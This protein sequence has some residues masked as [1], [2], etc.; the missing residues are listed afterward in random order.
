MKRL[1]SLAWSRSLYRTILFFT[2]LFALGLTVATQFE[3][4]TLGILTKKG[5]DFF[6]LFGTTPKAQKVSYDEIV[7]RFEQIDTGH[8]GSINRENIATFMESQPKD[9]L[10]DKL[11]DKLNKVLPIEKNALALALFITGVAILKAVTLFSYRFGTKLFAVY[12]G[13]DIRQRY[14]EHIQTLPMSFYQVHNIGALSSRAV[15]DAYVIADGINSALTNYIQTPFAMVSSIALCLAVSWKLSLV[16]FLGVP[17]VI[18]AIVFL[19]RRIRTISR[20]LQKK[21]ESFASVL[22]EYLNGIQ[23]IKLFAM[24][25]FSLKKYKE[26]NDAMAALEIKNARYDVSARPILH[27]IGM[28]FL[29]CTIIFGL[30]GLHLPLYEV[31]FFCGLLYVAYEPIKKFAEENGRIQR[32]IAACDRLFEVL[33]I[34][35]AITDEKEA[36][37]TIPY[38]EAIRFNNVSFQY[39][40]HR[41]ALS[42]VSFTINKGE[43]IAVVG[44]TGGGKSTIVSL[45]ARLFEP[46]EGSITID[47]FPIQNYTQKSLRDFFAVVPQRPFLFIDTVKENIRFGRPYTDEEV[48]EAA[49]KAHAEEF[50]THLSQGYDTPLAEAGKTLSGG[51]Q[52]RIAIARALIKKSPVLI[53]DEATSSLDTE[54]EQQIKLALNE[55]KGSITQIVIAHRLTTIEGA[56]RI[57]V[58]DKGQIVGQGTKSELL[59]TCGIFQRLYSPT[60]SYQ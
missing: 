53:L 45:L 18:G 48:I 6:A 12:M 37:S 42:S 7:N 19:A 51:Q 58:I 46:Q 11:L 57:I 59:E 14:F 17:F 8:T 43:M 47:G 52:Q 23:T 16:V 28:L 10:I 4:F 5:P 39:G 30:Y 44:P 60:S 49:R 56:D 22:V 2:L 54:S 34:E 3:M 41:N 21:Q 27:T 35:P 9:G 55:L 40:S 15:N 20:Q 33:D 32:A 26:N 24:E 36:K 50:I 29:V 38:S 31:L 1:I 13:R 25:D